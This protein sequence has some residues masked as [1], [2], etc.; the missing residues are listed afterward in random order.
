MDVIGR[1]EHGVADIED[2]ERVRKLVAALISALN[3]LADR[4]VDA[5]AQ[6]V[7]R[8]GLDALGDVLRDAE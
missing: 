3:V 1:I 6:A 4:G 7:I 2:A 5:V 8:R